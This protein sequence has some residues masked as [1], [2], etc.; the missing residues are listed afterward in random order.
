MQLEQPVICLK[1]N[2]GVV[3]NVPVS[4]PSSKEQ[5]VITSVCEKLNSKANNINSKYL[6]LKEKT[7]QLLQSILAKSFKGELVE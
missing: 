1:K 6:L 7:E 4:Y 3:S 2:Q 5:D